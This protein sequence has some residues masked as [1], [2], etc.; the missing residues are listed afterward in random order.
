MQRFA[1]LL[2]ALLWTCLALY[3]Q[4]TAAK[5][6]SKVSNFQLPDSSGQIRSLR[7]FSG[8]AVALIFWSCKCPVSVAYADRIEELKRKYGGKG[9]EVLAIDASANETPAEIRANI[10]NLKL[11]IPVLLDSEGSVSEELGATHSP[12]VFI[13]DGEGILRYKGAFDNNKR[14]GEGGRINYA[15]AALDSLLSGREIRVAETRPFGCSIRP[16]KENR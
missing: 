5:I 13:L 1:C 6:G 3:S 15:E 12:S 16:A 10:A 2:G 4:A 11:T 9:V 14:P 8:K 7:S